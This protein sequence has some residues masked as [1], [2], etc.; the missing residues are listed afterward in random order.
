MKVAAVIPA[1]NEERLI[2]RTLNSVPDI[3]DKIYV[4]DDGS[5]D[6][7][8]QIV[9]QCARSD[10]RINLV[11]HTANKGVGAAIITGYQ[12]AY[13]DENDIFVVVGGDAQMD[14]NDVQ[15]LI[16]PIEKGEADYTKGNRFIYGKSCKSSGNAWVEMPTKRILGN[17]TLSILTKFASGYYHLFDSQMG[18]TALYRQVFPLIDWGS[19]RQGYGYP[20]EW[21][22]RFHSVGVRV[23][24][25]PVRAIYLRDERQTKIRVRKFIF[26]MLAVIIKGGLHRVYREYLS[27]NSKKQKLRTSHQNTGFQEQIRT[28]VS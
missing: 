11:Q 1:L 27:R 18:Y 16:E 25:V 20:A 2:A 21:L 9:I 28:R 26:Y 24:D 13:E 4:I 19:V 3:I 15:D 17:V 23:R 5:S 7:T 12:R 6:R 14:W 22:M 8:A 10:P